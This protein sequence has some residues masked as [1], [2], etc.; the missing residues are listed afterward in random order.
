M[1]FSATIGVAASSEQTTGVVQV[2]QAVTPM[3]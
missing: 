2:G 3:D 1:Q